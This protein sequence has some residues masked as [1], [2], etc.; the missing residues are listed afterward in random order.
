MTDQN[1]WDRLARYVS[2]ESGATER[3]EVERWAAASAAN[4]AT[5]ETLR[6]GWS[7]GGDGH[8]WNVDAAWGRL[9][10]RLRD[11]KP[12]PG[13][14]K[15]V[16]AEPA[17][18]RWF[19]ITRLIPLAAAAALVIAVALRLAP[20]GESA[21]DGPAIALTAPVMR[22]GIG[23]QRTIDLAD[24]SQVMLGANSS[25]RLGDGFGNTTR[26]VFLEGQA[27]LRV[28]HD[29]A[30]PFVVNAAG[31]RATDLGTAFEVR[32]YPNE[33]VRVAVTEG[34]VEVRREGASA[35]STVL[36]PGDVA[37]LPATGDAVIRRQQDVER[38]LG[39][40]RGELVFD[41]APLADIGRELERW[42]DVQVRIDDPALR[43]LH[44]NMN[45]RIGESLDEILK[46]VELSLSSRGVR[47][48][49]NG[50]VVTFRSGAPVS[51]SAL[52]TGPRT[53]VE[54]GA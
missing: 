1:D 17:P 38:L 6:R 45:L 14:V 5:L 20:G 12:E 40:T 11:V 25:L 22:T 42:Y 26:E 39:W 4:R 52:P 49:R 41:D 54:A 36:H 48:E 33:G 34:L 19:R 8:S 27:F 53:R 16:P 35:D 47:A 13:I 51:P 3:A 31:T 23:E 30:R 24:G 7:A 18:S 15:L 10:P 29:A 44:M 21:L 43:T 50:N 46:L 32:A 9:S 2:G 37:E 28:R